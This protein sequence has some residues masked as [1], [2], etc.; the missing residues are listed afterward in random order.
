MG[1]IKIEKE[2]KS[3]I[4]PAPAVKKSNTFSGNDSLSSLNSSSD[5]YEYH[6]E[7][8]RVS[9]SSGMAEDGGIKNEIGIV[10]ICIRTFLRSILISVIQLFFLGAIVYSLLSFTGWIEP[11]KSFLSLVITKTSE[12]FMAYLLSFLLLLFVCCI[13]KGNI[14]GTIRKKFNKYYLRKIHIYIYDV[15]VVFLNLVL[16]VGVAFFFFWYVNHYQDV[17]TWLYRIHFMNTSQVVLGKFSYFKYV[18]VILISLFM[19][20]NS[21]KDIG[22]IHKKNQFVFD[23]E[24]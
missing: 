12:G 14:N 15:F 18:I 24:M 20:L 1:I 13:L 22:I 5:G 17:F 7:T 6:F 8:E 9:A 23:E 19:S 21:I 16:Y 3:N 10:S 4:N 2:S 11:F